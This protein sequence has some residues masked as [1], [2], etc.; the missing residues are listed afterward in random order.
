MKKFFAVTL[1]A[2]MTAALFAG[3]SGGGNSTAGTSSAGDSGSTADSKSGD[4]KN[5]TM[6]GGWGGDQVAQLDK[7]LASYNSSQEN[8]TVKYAVQTSMEEKLLTAIAGGQVPDIVLWDRFNTG[9]YADKGALAPLDDL[10]KRDSV[11]MTQFYEPAV[12]E[13]K[14][15]EVTYGIPL[16][17]DCRILFYNKTLLDEAGVDP[18]S[19]K[20][21]DSLRD[22]AIKL[23]KRDSGGKL[24]QSGF[25]VKDV[26]LFSMW[27]KQAGG[28]IIDDTVDPA[29][30]AFNNEKGL[31]V[32]E[33]WNTLQ[34]EDKVYEVGFEDAFGGDAFKAGK[35][36]LSYNGPW[37]IQ[38]YKDAGLDFGVIEPPAGKNGDKFTGMGGFGLI[39]PNKAKSVDE[40][41]DFIKWWTTKPENGVEFA[42]ISANLPAN[43]VAAEDAYF[44]EDP[45]LAPF[46]TTMLYAGIRSKAP[47]YSDFE[48]LATIPQLQK[49]MAGEID[50]QTALN[51]AEK[52]GNKLL[53]DAAANRKSK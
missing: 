15:G 10:I 46:S 17:V 50:A 36:A 47:G 24:T 32:L 48:G 18:A 45:Y 13:L 33:Y 31:E 2:F 4:K 28:K 30:S 49:F 34:N 11:D 12:E 44:T 41:W 26:G 1:A 14:V 8:I 7:Q 35:L 23:T 22:A 43:K 27:L 25:S 52:Q 9:V 16:T 40:A 39:I 42:K 53:A 37:S 19:I 6:W 51:E 29:V 20:D 3:C 38:G 21:W 5:I